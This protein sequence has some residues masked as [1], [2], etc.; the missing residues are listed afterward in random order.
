[1][2]VGLLIGWVVGTICGAAMVCFF[3]GVKSEC[4]FGIHRKGIQ[5]ESKDKSS[6]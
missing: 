5:N 3:I 6:V 2:L 4:G 1:M